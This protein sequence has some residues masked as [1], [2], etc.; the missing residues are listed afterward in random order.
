ME[1]SMY[2][3]SA[4]LY[5]IVYQ[6]MGK[7]YP[8]EA[9]RVHELIEKYKKTK[10]KDLLDVACGTG[11]HTGLLAK[12]YQVE[13][14]DL[15]I[16]MLAVAR[17]KYPQLTF[18]AGDM[19]TFD[20]GRQFDAV[21]CLFSSIGYM[22]TAADLE[23]ALC[24]MAGHLKPGGVLLVEP[25]FAPEEWHPGKVYATFVDQ[26]DL[27][28]ARMSHSGWKGKLSAFTFH[29]MVGSSSGVRTFAEEHV[30]AL[31]TRAEYLEAFAKT[32]LETVHDPEGIYGRGLYIGVK[33]A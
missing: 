21:T 32:G 13:G 12:Y 30:M 27:K 33:P 11:L 14:L 20:L 6:A 1:F 31:F 29:F 18:H 9:Q 16:E 26:P 8:A 23:Q 5:D 15:S 25:W 19:R 28:I 4:E 22:H 24:R 3:D 10:G 7:D 2:K 17:G